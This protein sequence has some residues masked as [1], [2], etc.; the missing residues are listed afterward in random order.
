MESIEIDITNLRE[1]LNNKLVDSGWEKMLSPYI[2]G[3]DFDHIMNTLVANV[4][5]GRR[6]TPRFKD[7]FNAFYEC[8]YDDVKVVIVGQDPYPQLGSADGIAFSC[9][10]KGKAEKSLQYILKALED[11]DGDVDLK[12]WANQ[13]VLLINT[14]FTVEINKIGSHY[15]IWKPFTEYL[16]E[17]LNRHKK[18]T[19]FI[20]M[21]KKAEEWQT[22]LPDCKI[23]KCPHPASAAYRGGVWDSKNVFNDANSILENQGKTMIN[24]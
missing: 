5:R 21:G 10:K 14:A 16:F 22:L 23:L 11:E 3:L 19:V 1:S 18:N 20:L 13:G 9:S 4:N 8:P 6:F 24:W 15:H 17:N 7:V 2:N 12:R